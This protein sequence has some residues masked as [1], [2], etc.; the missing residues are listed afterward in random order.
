MANLKRDPRSGDPYSLSDFLLRWGESSAEE[1]LTDEQIAAKVMAIFG[2][3][4]GHD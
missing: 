4:A 1:E 2:A 3:M